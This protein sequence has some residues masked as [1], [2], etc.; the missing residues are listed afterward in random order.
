[1]G[2]QH[3]GREVVEDS[4]EIRAWRRLGTFEKHHYC[5]M[6]SGSFDSAS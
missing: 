6:S 5:E 4:A 1:M 2:S 3:L